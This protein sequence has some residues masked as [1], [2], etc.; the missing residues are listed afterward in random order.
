MTIQET[1]AAIRATRIEINNTRDGQ[2]IRLT[3]L[4]DKMWDLTARYNM[5]L[6][7]SGID[8]V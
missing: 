5:L 8:A 6:R 7:V 3:R 1:A 4:S 2:Q